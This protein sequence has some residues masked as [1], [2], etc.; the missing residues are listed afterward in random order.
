MNIQFATCDWN[1]AK[2]FIGKM[3][4]NKTLD[5]SKIEELIS[6]IKKDILRVED[7]DF[8]KPCRIT[9][10]KKYE[11]KYDKEIKTAI[12]NFISVMS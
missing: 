8:H 11:E 12:S 5:E 2:E 7:P 4:P 6:L 9:Q 10:G 1:R 3:Y